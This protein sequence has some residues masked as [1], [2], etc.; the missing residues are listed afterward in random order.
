MTNASGVVGRPAPWV[1]AMVLGCTALAVRPVSWG[2][3]AATALV[4]AAGL[5]ASVRERPAS[6]L[7]I[8]VVLGAGSAA[9]AGARAMAAPVGPALDAAGVVAVTIAAVAEEAFFRRFLYAR[10]QR[11]GAAAAVA[12]PAVLFAAV[13][14]PVYG[15]GVL[16]IDLAAGAVLGWQRWASGTWLVPA[17][18]HVFANL[19]QMG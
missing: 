3:L 1:P 12:V 9:F 7:A 10:L 5:A 14:V 8:A 15:P 13:H 19:L 4:G 6:P 18:T 11:F 17:V 2:S 16:G